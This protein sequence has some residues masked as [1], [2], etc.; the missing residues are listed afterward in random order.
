MSWTARA[1]SLAARLIAICFPGIAAS[2]IVAVGT[3]DIARLITQS[4]SRDLPEYLLR[5]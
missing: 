1:S 4:A 2:F 3:A 5:C